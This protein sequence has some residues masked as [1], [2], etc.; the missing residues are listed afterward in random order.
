MKLHP[1]SFVKK[2][3]I[4]YNQE[5]FC[6]RKQGFF[7]YCFSI[8]QNKTETFFRALKLPLL[9]TSIYSHG[10]KINTQRL[11]VTYTTKL[12][13]ECTHSKSSVPKT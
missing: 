12:V 4:F 6:Q 3:S 2:I 5:N 1:H 10:M 9:S 7:F 11:C 8:A 13:D